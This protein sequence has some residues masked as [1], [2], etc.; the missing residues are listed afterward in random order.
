[1][2]SASKD[3]LSSAQIKIMVATL[4]GVECGWYSSRFVEL[5]IYNLHLLLYQAEI[6]FFDPVLW[7]GK[8]K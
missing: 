1:M 5:Q 2:E 4:Y 7:K 3:H 6:I 8:N